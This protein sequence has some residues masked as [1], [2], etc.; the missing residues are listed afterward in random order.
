[1][2]G[3]DVGTIEATLDLNRDPFQAAWDP[4]VEEV[5]EFV[6]DPH[7]LVL[8]LNDD[9]ADASVSPFISSMTCA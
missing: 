8:D 9:E 2:S 5:H 6:D 4:I 3:F 1:M 7:T